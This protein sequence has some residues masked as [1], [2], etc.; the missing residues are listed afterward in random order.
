MNCPMSWNSA[1]VMVVAGEPESVSGMAKRQRKRDGIRW[2]RMGWEGERKE[3]HTVLSGE[4]GALEGM[5]ELGDR[6][7]DVVPLGGGFEEGDEGCCS[8]EGWLAFGWDWEGGGG[9][10]EG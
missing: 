2:D 3:Y 1:P 7:A 8:L 6:L 10:G 4:V 5:L 9:H